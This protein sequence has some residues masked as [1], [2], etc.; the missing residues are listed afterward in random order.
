MLGTIIILRS[1]DL[2]AQISV[3]RVPAASA[4]SPI[5]ENI[6]FN[7]KIK[8]NFIIKNLHLSDL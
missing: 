3:E 7:D 8:A 2:V 5:F 6:I 1:E 4:V